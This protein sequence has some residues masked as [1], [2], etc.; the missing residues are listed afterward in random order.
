MEQIKKD[1]IELHKTDIKL[2]SQTLSQFEKVLSRHSEWTSFKREIILNSLLDDNKLQ[3]DIND[4]SEYGF[5]GDYEVDIISLS[6]T[7]FLLK[8][9]SFILKNDKIKKLEIKW[10]VLNTQNGQ[11]LK[12][13][14]DS[15]IEVDI[16]MRFKENDFFYF[17]VDIPELDKAA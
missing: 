17:Y 4:I 5:L 3:F 13:I 8:S 7:C 2:N 14:L 15:N 11:V 6:N 10:R 9:M 1:S 12:N 16:K